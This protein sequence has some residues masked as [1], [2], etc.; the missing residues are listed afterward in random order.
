MIEITFPPADGASWPSTGAVEAGFD[1]TRLADA[2]E[3]AQAHET[4]WNRDLAA[5]IASSYFEPP[6]WNEALGPIAPRGAPNGLLTRHGRLVACWGDTRQVDMTFSVAKS[7]L[8]ILAGIAHDRGLIPDLDEPVCI[9]VNDDGFASPHNHTITWSHLLQ[10][11]SEWEGTLWGKPD[12]VDRYRDLDTEGGPLA[13]KGTPRPPQAPGTYWEYNDVR[14]NRLSLALLR[15]F[16]RPL[17]EVFAEAVMGPIGAS[18]SWHWEGYRNSTVEIDGRPILSVPGGGHWGGGV[19]IHAEDQARIGLM[20]LARGDWVARRVLSA[21]WIDR[22]THPCPIYPTYGCL[23]WLN[24]DR[25]YYP[26][27]SPQSF[28]AIGAGGNCTWIDPA[29]GIVAVLRWLDPAATNE[30]IGLVIGALGL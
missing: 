23:W 11:T 18:A 28:F 7:Y 17:P 27:A 22:A 9:R 5:V 1:C 10:Q 19:F 21:R 4:P 20:M 14:V 6:P 15:L 13:K 24:T 30:F 29:S 8:S 26:N 12:I 25:G 3:F 2:V 16:R